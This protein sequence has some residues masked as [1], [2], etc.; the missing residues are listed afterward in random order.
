MATY[1]RKK[2][3]I[4][5]SFAVYQDDQPPKQQHS[6]HSANDSDID[7]LASTS[8]LN[9]RPRTSGAPTIRNNS[10]L[11]DVAQTEDATHRQQASS[12]PLP[13]LPLKPHPKELE[14][15]KG[16][17]RVLGSKSTNQ[18]VVNKNDQ[19]PARPKISA[20]VLISST[21]NPLLGTAGIGPSVTPDL[22][23]LNDKISTLTRQADAQE[24]ETTEKE[25][26]LAAAEAS[27]RP[28]PLQR[29]KS[30]LATAKRAIVARLGS[31]RIKL[32][33]TSF[34]LNRTISGPGYEPI[35]QPPERLSSEP[36]P[37]P[38][39]ESMRHRRETPEPQESDDPFS[40]KMEMDEAWSEFEINFDRHKH[41]GKSLRKAPSQTPSLG[42]TPDP[43]S[44]K[45]LLRSRS[46]INYSN[47]ISGLSQHPTGEWFSSSP[48]GFSTPR[49]CLAP[50][51]DAMGNRRLSAVL[52]RDPSLLMEFSFEQDSTDDEADP[53]VQNGRGADHSSNM[54]RKSGS[55]YPYAQA[56]KRAKTASAA[57]KETTV[58]AQGLNQLG[59]GDGQPVNDVEMS[60]AGLSK[61]KGFGI[62][63]M[64]KGKETET[65]IRDFAETT[66]VRRHS[67]QHSSVSRPTS[68]L[69]SRETRA[70]AP[71]LKKYDE[72]EMDVDELQM[73]DTK[74]L[75][76]D[77]K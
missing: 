38:V 1:G 73:E 12:K 34:P 74:M 11:S 16:K 28:S 24:A 65:S 46:P 19:I 76:T 42:A 37:L 43:A 61:N 4:F 47:Q 25:R 17:R 18:K 9:L 8:F 64:G 36:R 21:T 67:R 44:E 75:G 32:G 13:P 27:F 71:L 41:K 54:K 5:P 60:E 51:S 22:S 58:L 68:V 77:L 35:D 3:P 14:K 40:D 7:E 62:F 70:R 26:Q 53:L 15:G 10:L 52:V 72:D 20:P 39:Y 31:P 59:T 33:R 69:F 29:G 57:S 45:L 56:P 63:D 48:V 50:T 2:R 6:R 30:V 49:L 66:S 55:E 23:T